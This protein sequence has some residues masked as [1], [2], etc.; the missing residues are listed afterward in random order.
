MRRRRRSPS[1]ARSARPSA[2]LPRCGPGRHGACRCRAAAPP[3][4]A[5]PAGTPAAATGLASTQVSTRCRSTVK[6]CTADADGR[7]RMPRHSGSQRSIRPHWSSSSHTGTRPGP[8]ASRR[9]SSRRAWSGHGSGSSGWLAASRAAVLG[10]SVRPFVAAAVAA[11][12]ASQG[13]SRGWAACASTT[14]PSSDATP[15]P[16]R[17]RAGRRLVRGQARWV[18]AARTWSTRRHVS[19]ARCAVRLPRS[20]TWNASASGLVPSRAATSGISSGCSRSPRRPATSCRVS[21]TSSSADR[22]ASPARWGTSTSQVAT[23]ARST[24]PS[25]RPPPDSL[26]SGTAACARSPARSTRWAQASFSSGS[27]ARASRRQSPRTVERSAM[28]RSTSPATCRAS[29]IPVA[30]RRSRDAMSR[31]DTV[32]RTAWSSGTPSSHSGY[33]SASASFATRSPDS[34]GSCRS[35]TSMSLYGDSSPR[36]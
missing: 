9:T 19:W 14:S 17:T 22:C 4:P 8:A 35:T 23:S 3:P 1:A 33:Q 10:A 28:L 11:L 7:N 32:S 13:S 18:G 21:R 12:S 26:R 15:P 16:S 29:S 6:R 34:D 30:A 24:A 31:I 20:R 2:R 25:R 27:R 36:P 5:G